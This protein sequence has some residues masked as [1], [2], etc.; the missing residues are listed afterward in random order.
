MMLRLLCE[1]NPAYAAA[2]IVAHE[3]SR[4]LRLVA[5]VDTI[6]SPI[7]PQESAPLVQCPCLTVLLAFTR[8]ESQG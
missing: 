8:N 5:Q 2:M 1:T 7:P 6:E 3:H 4:A